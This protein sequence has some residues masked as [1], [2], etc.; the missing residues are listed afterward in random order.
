M[1]LT[2]FDQLAGMYDRSFQD[3]PFR[4]HVEQHSV[5]DALGD[6][7]G[8]RVLDMGCGSGAYTRVIAQRGAR[9]VTGADISEG[10]IKYAR[11]AEQHQPLSIRYFHH[12]VRQPILPL[13]A[14]CDAVLAVYVLPYATTAAELQSMCATARAALAGP[15]S[16]FIA[17][18]LNPQV[19][20]SPHY[21]QPYT[22]DLTLPSDRPLRDGDPVRLHSHFNGDSFDVTSYY[23]SRQT[24]EDALR[25]A[26]FTSVSWTSP[27]CSPQADPA[28]Y[29]SYLA[30]PHA[31]IVTATV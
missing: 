22:F 10:M 28:P 13:A 17:A 29:T 2:Q 4:T 12:D 8:L 7:T 1:S 9:S 21:Y 18:T 20:T 15:G 5:L 11:Q 31:M 26:G 3:L 6:L 16:R 30:I 27:R 24:H 23:W 25:A 19:A 14:A